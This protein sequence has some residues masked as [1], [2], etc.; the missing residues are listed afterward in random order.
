MSLQVRAIYRDGAFVVK[1]PCDLPQESEVDLIVQGPLTM[2]P[3]ETDPDQ[4]AR[5]LRGVTQR[6]RN[7]PIPAEAPRYTRDEL[8]ERR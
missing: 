5:V 1:Q 7:N 4:R 8:H 6:M 2:P 3:I